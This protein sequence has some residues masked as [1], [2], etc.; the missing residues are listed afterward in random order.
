MPPH[1][2]TYIEVD[3]VIATLKRVSDAG[4]TVIEGPFEEAGVGTF[5][6]LRDSVG[7]FLRIWHSAP[8]TGGE[9]FNVPGAMN[10]NELNTKEPGKAATFCERVLDIDLAEGLNSPNI[11]DDGQSPGRL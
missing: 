4:G 9:V 2:G 8:E 5:G 10:W 6:V 1:W 7:A 11:F 3:D